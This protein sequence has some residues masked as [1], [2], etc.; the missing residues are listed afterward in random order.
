MIRFPKLLNNISGLQLYQLMRF[1]TFLLISI[2]FTK[3]HLDPHDIGEFEVFLFIASLISFF[4]VSGLIQS[5]L[6]LYHR[7]H[8]FKTYGER[9]E[10]K[11]PEIF[12]A[13]LLLTSFSFGALILGISLKHHFSVFHLSGDIPFINLL[14]AYLFLSNPPVLIEY[15]Y[16]LQNKPEYIFRY[17][18]LTHVIQFILVIAPLIAGYPIIWAIWGLLVIS[19]ARFVWLIILL[20]RYAEFRISVPFIREHLHYGAPLIMSALL[21]GSAQYIDGVIVT[22]KFDAA[23]FALFRYGAKELPFTILLANGLS[24]AMLPEFSK[25]GSFRANLSTLRTKSLRL[26]HFLYPLSMIILFFARWLYPRL[27]NP[28]FQRSA[29]IFMIYLLLIIPRLVFPQ[30]ILIGMKKTRVVMVTAFIEIVLNVSLSLYLLK[31]YD[32]VG[33]ALA[34]VI[35][36][37]IEKAILVAYLWIRMKVHP[38]TYIPL[39]TLA[40]YATAIIILFVLIDH[41]ITNVV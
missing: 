21:S 15:I 1:T 23:T 39:K 3:I 19:A 2:I 14:L 18:L 26:M 6:P 9:K 37:I 28:S 32:I 7:N 10:G 27:F 33:I 35:V 5:F 13:A 25:K 36:F 41:R 30:T 4:W 8:T 40:I 20:F 22:N 24:N 11:S 29:D 34:T 31:Y 17:G 12:N 38:R 16:L